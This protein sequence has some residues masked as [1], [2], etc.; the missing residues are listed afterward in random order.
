MCL[1][2]SGK[3]DYHSIL[4]KKKY[5]TGIKRRL[6]SIFINNSLFI[7][8]KTSCFPNEI[9]MSSLLE[10]MTICGGCW[11]C[12]PDPLYRPGHLWVLWVLAAGER[13]PMDRDRHTQKVICHHS[14]LHPHSSSLQPTTNTGIKG[15]PLCSCSKTSHESRLNP[16][17]CLD[18]K[19]V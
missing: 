2:Q 7:S 10:L 12:L 8:Q 5:K 1:F 19:L 3:H 15:L 6:R 14:L 4:L 16:D 9:V 13:L 18:H 17:H 11:W